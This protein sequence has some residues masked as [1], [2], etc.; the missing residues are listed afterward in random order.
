[1]YTRKENN[2]GSDE[3]NDIERQSLRIQRKIY[4]AVR[5]TTI[6]P[7]CRTKN[8]EEPIHN[9]PRNLSQTGSHILRD[10]DL[11]LPFE[12]LHS[13]NYL[14]QLPLLMTPKLKLLKNNNK[15]PSGIF[16]RK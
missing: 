13:N 6:W 12:N 15:S 11:F 8:E 14:R 16:H 7:Q 2:I 10:T 1:M 9:D 3:G 5:I 4:G